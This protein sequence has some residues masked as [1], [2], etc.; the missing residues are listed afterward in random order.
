MIFVWVK[1]QAAKFQA[2][3]LI[4]VFCSF[5][6]QN[7]DERV[8]EVTLLEFVFGYFFPTNKKKIAPQQSQ[9]MSDVNYVLYNYIYQASLL[10]PLHLYTQQFYALT[11]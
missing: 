1:C 8:S 4:A 9:S 11:N 7:T 3:N 10:M 6:S 5:C 2:S